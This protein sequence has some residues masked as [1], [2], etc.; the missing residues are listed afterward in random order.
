MTQRESLKESLSPEVFDKAAKNAAQ[1]GN[2]LS[3]SARAE[4]YLDLSGIFVWSK[5]PE[6]HRFWNDVCISLRMREE[7]KQTAED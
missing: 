4:A 7:A 5:T 2:D 3:M 6:G 1:Q